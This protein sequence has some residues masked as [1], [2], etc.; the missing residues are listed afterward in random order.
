ML[1]AARCAAER[2][3][4][5]FGKDVEQVA[6]AEKFQRLTLRELER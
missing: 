3:A 2:R 1:F 4:C 6:A 5:M